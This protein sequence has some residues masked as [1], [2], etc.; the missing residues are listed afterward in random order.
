MFLVINESS[1]NFSF[2]N[3]DLYPISWTIGERPNKVI[4]LLQMTEELSK[5]L[6]QLN[7]LILR[8]E[9][10]INK[11]GMVTVERSLEPLSK[12]K[13]T[14]W[15]QTSTSTQIDIDSDHQLMESTYEEE[16]PEKS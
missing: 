7:S 10:T 2:Y 3:R 16:K 12:V 8:I 15:T 1:K 14:S 5:S 6:K 9:K 4:G 11:K 13:S